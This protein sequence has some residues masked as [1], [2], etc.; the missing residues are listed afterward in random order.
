MDEA[1]VIWALG[2]GGSKVG[3][4]NYRPEKGGMFGRFEVRG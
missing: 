1:S 2:Q 4:G 3:V